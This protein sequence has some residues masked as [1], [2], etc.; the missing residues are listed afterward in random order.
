MAVD[1]EAGLVQAARDLQPLVREHADAAERERRVPAP[2]IEAMREAGVFHMMVPGSLGGGEAHVATLIEVIEAL[3]AADGSAGWVAMIGA[4]TGITSAYLED[5]T[6]REIYG[7]R[8]TITGGVVAPS[9]TATPVEGGFR[10]S[11][12][13]RFG[14]GC[15][16]SAWMALAAVVKA[17][18][19]GGF[20]P[21]V[22][23]FFVPAGEFE[24]IDTWDVGGLRGT[25]SHDV[26]VDDVFVPAERAYSLVGHPRVTGP[27]Y[28]FSLFGL[29]AV[30]VSAVALGIA[31]GALDDV[32]ELAG[33]RVP[34]GKRR[35]VADW[36]IGQAD[37]ARAE[38]SLRAGRA[39][40]L[41]AVNDMWDTVAA[42]EQAT[43]EQR[44]QVRLAASWAAECS[45]QAV[46]A[47][48]RL[49][50]GSA[51]YATSPLQR[52]FRD[53]HTLTQ[54]VII[55]PATYE[56]VGRVL[57]GHTLPPGFL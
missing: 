27:L 30:A 12:R 18:E 42:G 7:D 11:G 33:A 51:V 47:A 10:L 31:R 34:L 37:F 56:N 3:S 5:S 20:G 54:H 9:G 26:A 29:L 6:A 39:F 25:G 32:R 48:Y 22:R 19:A 57:F 17:E 2:V 15:E 1:Q 55:G 21:D 14:S 8:A 49:G 28:A 40:L 24:V 4:T 50:G 43:A 38:A 45:V 13:W 16:H 35:P 44:A 41:E 46:D 53:I 52:R 36:A 23:M